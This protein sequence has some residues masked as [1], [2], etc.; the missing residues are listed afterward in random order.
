MLKVWKP[1][2]FESQKKC[3]TSC[4]WSTNDSLSIL[5]SKGDDSWVD[6]SYTPQTKK[7]PKRKVVT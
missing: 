4:I 2:L 3:Y 6:T 7:K 5:Y 1:N